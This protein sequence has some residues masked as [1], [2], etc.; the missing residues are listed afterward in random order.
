MAGQNQGDSEAAEAFVIRRQSEAAARASARAKA[1]QAYGQDIRRGHGL[2]LR[3]PGDLADYGLRL[4]SPSSKPSQSVANR[5]TAANISRTIAE[6]FLQADTAVRSAANTLTFGGADK[7]EAAMAALVAPGGLSGWAQRYDAS[8]RQEQA[9][10]SYD[11]AHRQLA[12]SIGSL[13]GGVLGLLALG[14]EEAAAA[15]AP[16]LAGAAKLTARE[17]GGVLGA[18]GLTGLGAQKLSDFATGHRSSTGDLVGAVAGGVAGAAALPFGPTRAGAVDGAVTSL[19]QD[20]FNGRPVSVAQLSQSAMAGGLL[21]GFAG[22][23]GRKWSDGLTPKAKGQL[24]ETL[25][26]ARAWL[27]AEQRMRIPKKRAPVAEGKAKTG[28]KGA[29]WYPDATDGPIPEDWSQSLPKMFEDK[30]GYGAELSDN[31]KVAQALLGGKFQLNHFTPNDVGLMTG[32]PAG[33]FGP[34]IVNQRR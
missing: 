6:P 13:S 18:G 29:Y 30:F 19:A 10:N 24:G 16:R 26:D 17:A 9:R 15:A 31:Q 34:Q 28:K 21:S 14:P 23:A 4:S 25:G 1:H 20:L 11:A 32:L 12:Q 8:L 22:S 2:E 3:Q 27:N 7:L 33:G 5:P